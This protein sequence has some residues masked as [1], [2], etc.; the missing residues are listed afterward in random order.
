MNE[1]ADRTLW[2][3]FKRIAAAL[4]VLLPNDSHYLAIVYSFA[5][6]LCKP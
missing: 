3:T 1:I 4:Q 6:D 5:R 2:N